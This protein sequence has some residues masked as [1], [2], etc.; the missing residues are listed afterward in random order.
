MRSDQPGLAPSLPVPTRVTA[1]VTAYHPDARL[2]QVVRSAL[3]SCQAV[4]V[5]DNTPSGTTSVSE[6]LQDPRVMVKRSG[7]NEG[8]A[9]A[10]NSGLAELGSD[11]QAVLLL[12]QDSQLPEDLV[13]RLAKHLSDPSIGA[14]GPAPY[15]SE[16]GAGYERFENLHD[17]LDDRYSLITSGMLVR[18][19]SFDLVPSFRSDF[20]VDWVD[21]DFCLRLRRA[22]VRVVLDRETRLPHDIGDGRTHRFLWWTTRVLHYAPWRHYWMARNGLILFREHARALPGWG[23]SYVLYLARIV[24]NIML[25]GPERRVHLRAVARGFRDAVTGQRSGR[26]LPPNAEHPTHER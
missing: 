25:F 18:R 26:Y 14:V 22:G 11:T 17:V 16:T 5:I 10:L 24:F 13:P 7:R 8:L 6:G 12:D 19:D 23:A 9:T 1:L 2:I 15:D 20:F 3:E 21:N 4:I